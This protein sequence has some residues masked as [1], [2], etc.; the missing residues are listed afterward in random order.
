MLAAL[1]PLALGAPPAAD[2][3]NI[4]GAPRS[5]APLADA[6]PP[7]DAPTDAQAALVQA[8]AVKE[9]AP[10]CAALDALS[11]APAADYAWVVD[12][13]TAPPWSA[14][15]AAECLVLGHAATARPTLDRWLTEP[16]LKGLGWVVLKHLDQLEP[17]LAKELATLSLEQGPDPEGTRRRLKRSKSPEIQALGGP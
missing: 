17:A 9:P 8:L 10:T 12:H 5:V 1:L 2:A 14:M 3:S 15:R 4:E 6:A 11:P 7:A 13:V 16:R